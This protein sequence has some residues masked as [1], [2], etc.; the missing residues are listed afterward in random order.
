M[1]T[2]VANQQLVPIQNFVVLAKMRNCVDLQE[3]IY[4]G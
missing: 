1:D 4:L 3:V 2:S